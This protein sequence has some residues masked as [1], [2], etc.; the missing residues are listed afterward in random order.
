MLV[1][2]Q[3]YVLKDGV[4]TILDLAEAFAK[5]GIDIFSLR[6]VLLFWLEGSD[7]DIDQPIPFLP[8]VVEMSWEP[9]GRLVQLVND[10]MHR[11]YAAIKSRR[12]INI[13]LVS[14]VPKQFPYYAYAL[15]NGWEQ[16]EEIPELTDGY[17]KKEYRNPENYKALFRDFNEI[18]DGVQKQRKQTIVSLIA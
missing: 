11:V 5:K 10:G 9:D 1:P 15:P 3:R 6:G 13:V 7:P 8:P 12:N 14:N 17:K 16:V 2:P 4:Q 18:F